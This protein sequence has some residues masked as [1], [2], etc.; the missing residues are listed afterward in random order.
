MLLTCHSSSHSQNGRLVHLITRILVPKTRELNSVMKK[1]NNWLSL[2]MKEFINKFSS[3][4]TFLST[5]RVDQ[6][7][8]QEV[9]NMLCLVNI[10]IISLMYK[11][12][13]SLHCWKKLKVR[14]ANSSNT[15]KWHWSCWPLYFRHYTL[16]TCKLSFKT[17][18]EHL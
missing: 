3:Y 10:Q 4:L 7:T 9:L 16:T 17:D 15:L 14:H 2:A 6:G 18:N 12:K 11:K 1:K 5:N 13:S 8:G